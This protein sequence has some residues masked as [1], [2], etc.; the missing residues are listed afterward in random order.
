ML[1]LLVMENQL[2]EI[3]LNGKSAFVTATGDISTML[4]RSKLITTSIVDKVAIDC[5]KQTPFQKK[6]T[7]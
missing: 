6:K 7:S 5:Q 2:N 1:S 3:K 4:R